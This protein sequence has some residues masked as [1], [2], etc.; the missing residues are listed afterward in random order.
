MPHD[1]RS[2]WL[3]CINISTSMFLLPSDYQT[4]I[5]W[6]DCMQLNKLK[7]MSKRIK[8]KWQREWAGES[9]WMNTA[10]GRGQPREAHCLHIEPI[11]TQ[12]AEHSKSDISP[13]RFQ[14]KIC[15]LCE[16]HEQS[17][18]WALH[19]S[20]YLIRAT[21]IS[22]L[23]NYTHTCHILCCGSLLAYLIYFTH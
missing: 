1:Y 20:H 13:L 15:P 22:A 12:L 6:D 3:I 19:F 9:V 18:R 4:L 23:N 17:K 7:T 14:I 10:V 5:R 2:W 21:H 11:V 8:E 16:N